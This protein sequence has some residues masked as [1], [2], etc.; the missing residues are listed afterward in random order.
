MYD[1]VQNYMRGSTAVNIAESIESAIRD[2]HL[3]PGE[4]LPPV[5]RAAE[6]LGV[7]Q[8][9]VAAAYQAL[10]QR[11]LLVADGRRGTRV[12][13]R[14]VQPLWMDPALPPGVRDLYNNEADPALLPDLGGVLTDEDLRSRLYGEAGDDPELVALARSWFEAD[15]VPGEH[16]AVASGAGS[17][18]NGALREYAL[19]GDLVAVEDPGYCGQFD[20]IA[21]HR[22]TPVPVRVDDEGMLPEDLASALDRGCRVVVATPRC[23]SPRGAAITAERA[24]ALREVLDRRPDVLTIE[25]DYAFQL[26]ERA[27]H[28]LVSPARRRWVI[29]RSFNKSLGPDIRCAVFAGDQRTVDALKF[30]WSLSD[31]WVSKFLQRLAVGVLRRPGTEEMLRRAR[32]TYTR[33]REAALAALAGRGIEAFGADGL[34][35]WVPVPEEGAVVQQMMARG[36][37]VRAGERFRVASRPAVRISVSRLPEE[38]APELAADLAAVLAG[39]GR[40]GMP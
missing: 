10:Q 30:R 15:G 29:A 35:V 19:P 36:W 31:G 2:G 33:R 22:L 17:V 25:D 28:G 24:A 9:T 16:V 21:V 1:I 14:R 11:G 7:S 27:Y 23:Q 12:G 5:R 40:F 26:T 6:Q 37:G 20:L 39:R 8:G 3:P 4:K 38:D 18:V 34:N 13:Q 32:A